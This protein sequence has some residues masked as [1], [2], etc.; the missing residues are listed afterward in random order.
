MTNKTKIF[1][2]MAALGTGVAVVFNLALAASGGSLA[3]GL[4]VAVVAGVIAYRLYW[5]IV[6][7]MTNGSEVVPTA[8]GP[9]GHIEAIEYYWRPN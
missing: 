8:H 7:R 3:V 1:L 4:P 2:I 9:S 6:T 5:R